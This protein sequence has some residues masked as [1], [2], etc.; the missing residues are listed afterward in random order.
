[1][2]IPVVAAIAYGAIV[3]GGLAGAVAAAQRLLDYIRAP[4]EV[5][6][7]E[8]EKMTPIVSAVLSALAQTHFKVPLDRL[9]TFQKSELETEIRAQLPSIPDDLNAIAQRL[10]SRPWDSLADDEKGTVMQKLAERY[11]RRSAR[12]DARGRHN[13]DAG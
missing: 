13:R 9:S 12:G 4:R 5:Q 7:A 10:F 1:M 6:D 3:G 2:P 8:D 11:K